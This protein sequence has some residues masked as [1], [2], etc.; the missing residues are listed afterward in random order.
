M[1]TMVTQRQEVE[2]PA[3]RNLA[4]MAKKGAATDQN[5][6]R[7][8]RDRTARFESSR[9]KTC[10]P[11]QRARRSR[12]ARHPS[13]PP[14]LFRRR[15]LTRRPAPRAAEP[16][17]AGPRAAGPRAAAVAMAEAAGWP[18]AHLPLPSTHAR[19]RPSLPTRSASREQGLRH[20][21]TPLMTRR[22]RAAAPGSRTCGSR[23]KCGTECAKC[24]ET[25]G[26][27]EAA[28]AVGATTTMTTD[29]D[30][31]AARAVAAV[32]G[33]TADDGTAARAAVAAAARA[34]AAA[35]AVVARAQ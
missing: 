33:I 12:R 10:S 9:L 34:A 2:G 31:T 25:G 14:L 29:G 15:C 16:G 11:H 6:I 17:A 26:G 5:Q 24:V 35:A 23:T 7:T 22:V 4:T 32:A 28:G 18:S 27:S 1:R 30:G 8:Q 3:S 21:T 13:P 19:T 20:G